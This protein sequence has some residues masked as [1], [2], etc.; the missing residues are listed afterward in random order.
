MSILL[1]RS[2][3][4]SKSNIWDIVLFVLFYLRGCNFVVFY[5]V[6]CFILGR[7][8][9]FVSH[10]RV[11]ELVCFSFGVVLLLCLIL[12]SYS[13]FVSHLG[14][15]MVFCFI[16][17]VL[18][19]FGVVL[20]FL[21]YWRVVML[22]Y[23][24]FRVV[25]LFCFLFGSYYCFV[26]S[27]GRTSVLFPLWVVLLFCLLVGSYYCFVSVLGRTTVLFQIWV[28]LLFCFRFC[29]YTVLLFHLWCFIVLIWCYPL[30]SYCCYVLPLALYC[31]CC[32]FF[33]DPGALVTQ[34]VR[35]V[36]YLATHS[37][38]SPIRRGFVPGFVYYKKGALDSQPQ[39]IQ[40]TSCLPMVGGSPQVLRLPPPLKLVTMK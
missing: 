18:S 24:T 25:L 19:H 38:L 34:W 16:F 10:F 33:P 40:F 23:F 8:C 37:S 29:G 7:Y 32:F 14:I 35:Y 6:F 15:V 12:G 13:F 3:L 5:L 30:S 31:C 4:L 21:S 9:C 27:L 22:I 36:E 17:G 20:L 1:I 11:L 28:V 26:S 39:V 2:K